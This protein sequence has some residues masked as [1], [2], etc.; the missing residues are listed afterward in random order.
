M[1]MESTGVADC[2]WRVVPGLGCS[3]PH[4]SL[5]FASF[6][7][8]G[9]RL[10]NGMSVRWAVDGTSIK[11]CHFFFCMYRGFRLSRALGQRS[12]SPTDLCR[13]TN[14]ESWWLLLLAV[15]SSSS[16]AST[17]KTRHSS[18]T[19]MNLPYLLSHLCIKCRMQY[20]PFRAPSTA[21]PGFDSWIL[22][23]SFDS[24]VSPPRSH[25]P[26]NF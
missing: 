20:H 13:V 10:A 1:G 8:R 16:L 7:L 12:L 26:M 6:P 24:P 3:V 17:F 25:V 5:W 11:S 9:R 14:A 4:A 21:I 2:H 18:L 19:K 15:M 23:S 22:N